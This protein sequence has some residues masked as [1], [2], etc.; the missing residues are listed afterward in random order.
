MGY[1]HLS[2]NFVAR[3]NRIMK[4]YKTKSIIT[5]FNVSL[6]LLLA[7]IG[8]HTVQKI[9]GSHTEPVSAEP[10]TA[11]TNTPERD[12]ALASDSALSACVVMMRSVRQMARLGCCRADGKRAIRSSLD[13]NSRRPQYHNSYG[14]VTPGTATGYQPSAY[15]AGASVSTLAAPRKSRRF[16]KRSNQC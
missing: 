3:V 14:R 15:T 16:L 10:L 2:V 4:Q 11:K 7:F 5:L 8:Y 13:D 12:P 1:N 6:L 9:V